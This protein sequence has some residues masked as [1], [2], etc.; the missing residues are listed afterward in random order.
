MKPEKKL[1]YI[2]NYLCKEYI[3]ESISYKHSKNICQLAEL[4]VNPSEAYMILLKLNS[5]G[6]V[7]MLESNQWMF[8]INYN[9]ILFNRN[10]GYTQE[11][12]DSKRKRLK[13][14]IFNG[15]IAIGSLLAGIYAI[16]QIWIELTK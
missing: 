2:L 16:W 1:D 5:D 11:L 10:G 3:K 6:Y 4:D 9:G 8:Q 7:D 14:D 12:E 15:I 13:D